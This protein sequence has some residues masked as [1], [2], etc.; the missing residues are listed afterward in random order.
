ME[1]NFSAE[2]TACTH[3]AAEPLTFLR[4]RSILPMWLVINNC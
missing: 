1:A 3:D 2:G 4:E